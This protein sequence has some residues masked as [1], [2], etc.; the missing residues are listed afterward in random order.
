MFS[1]NRDR[2][3]AGD[4]AAKFFAQVLD[5]ARA[6]DLLSDEHF[7]VD[8]TLIEAWASQKAFSARTRIRL[9]RRTTPATR[10]LIFHGEKRSN[11]THQSTTDPEERLARKSSWQ[12]SN[13]AYCGNILIANRN[14][15]VVD[16]ALVMA[17]GTAERDAAVEMADLNRRRATRHGGRRQGL[18][19][20]RIRARD[21]R[22]EC[23]AARVWRTRIAA[24][25]ARWIV[26]RRGMPAIK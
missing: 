9:R 21:A 24:V 16:T 6:N 25:A 12:E 14:A 15:L 5:Q 26:A 3:L 10:P 20:A 2:L 23:D 17:S 13:L 4:I 1:K 7:S 18:R 8:G 22:A 19:H 11:D